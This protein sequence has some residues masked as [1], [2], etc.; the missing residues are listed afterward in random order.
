MSSILVRTA[1]TVFVLALVAIGTGF[2]S[3]FGWGWALF[4]LGLAGLLVH[5]VRHLNLLHLWASRSL[6]EAVPE[7][8]GAWEEVFT[9]LYR[10]QRAETARSRQLAHSLASLF[11][12]ITSRPMNSPPPFTLKRRATASSSPCSSFPTSTRSGCCFRAP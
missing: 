9:L 6:T 8:T 2:L 4:S 12:S 10:R 5:H 3:G 7:G 1:V 11:S